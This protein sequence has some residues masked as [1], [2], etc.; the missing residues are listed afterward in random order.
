MSGFDEKGRPMRVPGMAPTFE[1]TLIYPSNQGAT[2]WYSP[3]YSP[4]TGLFYIPAW[5]NTWSIYVKGEEAYKEGERFTSGMHR[6]SFTLNRGAQN[7]TRKP[8][9]GHGAVIAVDAKTG[10]K[11]WQ[12]DF[13][14]VTDSGI[15]TTATDLLFTG[16]RE[17]YFFALDARTGKA[18]WRASLGG[19]VASG[20]MTYAVN[21]KQYVAVAAGNALFVFGLR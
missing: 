10:E 18:L 3:S 14:D 12:F 21:G 8:E 17:E 2:N 7:N 11:K 4:R 9:D 19:A 20:P 16:N 6:S 5:D 15:L 13:V 1:G